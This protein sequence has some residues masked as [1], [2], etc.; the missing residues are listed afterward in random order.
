MTT[1]T[2]VGFIIA[3]CTAL[4][5][6]YMIGLDHAKTEQELKA[7]FTRPVLPCKCLCGLTEQTIRNI[8][9]KHCRKVKS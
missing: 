3:V 9:Y 5:A 7:R 4:F 1:D 2:I 8:T 6:G